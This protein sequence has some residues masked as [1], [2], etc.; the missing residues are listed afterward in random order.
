MGL[1][2]RPALDGPDDNLGFIL[3]IYLYLSS[4]FTPLNSAQLNFIGETLIG[5]NGYE[6][7]LLAFSL[8]SP[9]LRS[10]FCVMLLL[11]RF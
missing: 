1:A 9:L 3:P 6:Q 7:S 5:D 2:Q 11:F 10:R 8:I 4:S